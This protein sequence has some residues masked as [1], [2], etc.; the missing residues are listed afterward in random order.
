MYSGSTDPSVLVVG[1]Y[2]EGSNFATNALDRF[3]AADTATRE[4]LTQLN[5]SSGIY[6]PTTSSFTHPLN[7][8]I[9]ELKLYNKY[10]TIPETLALSA[11]GPTSLENIKFYLPPFFTQESPFRQSLN[12]QGGVLVTPF[13]TEDATTDTPFAN[14][15]AFSV[16][17]HYVNLENYVRDF[18]TGLYPRLWQ[19]SGS[20]FTPPATTE[21]SANDFLYMTG[22]IR[23]RLYTIL[24]CDN[25]IFYP[26]FNLLSPLSSSKFVNDIGNKE[27]GIVTLNNI[28]DGHFASQAI[29]SS[30][31][32]LTN[33]LGAQ[34][35]NITATPGDSLAILH[36]LRDGSSNQVVFFDVS[37]LFYG[38]RIK[39]GTFKIANT[40]ITQSGGALN[41]QIK[42]DGYGNLY[43][44][45]A[46]SSLA[47]WA[48]I[49]NIFYDEGLV[50]IK[51]PNLFFFG[52]N[53]FDVSFKGEQNLHVFTVNA[54]AKAMHETSSSNPSYVDFSINDLANDQDTKAVYITQVLIMDEDLNVII[55]SQ[56]AA[57]FLKRSSD[58][59]LFKTKI[60]Y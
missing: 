27:L 16:G 21:L 17:G 52:D 29:T 45:D 59:I 44:A 7:A 34:S 47:T 31:S 57:P 24:P 33:I 13:Y 40:A 26:N 43:R 23:K 30:G 53:Q 50:V 38:N 48:S 3:F 1:N 5:N 46:S 15:M 8:E 60:D 22:S 35:G 39:P 56:L 58:K 11:S 42:D 41:I 4:G 2:Y 6:A 36:N 19:L 14:K 12:G 55:R 9:H 10:L 25:G 49:G 54:F 32:I 18:A 37:N 51:H 20:E 28:V